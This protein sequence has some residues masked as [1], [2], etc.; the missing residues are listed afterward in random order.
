MN[1]RRVF[2]P[3][4]CEIVLF[5][6]TFGE[7]FAIEILGPEVAED[8]MRIRLRPDIRRHDRFDGMGDKFVVTAFGHAQPL[9]YAS[10]P[11][12]AGSALITFF[13]LCAEVRAARPIS[14]SRRARSNIAIGGAFPLAAERRFPSGARRARQGREVFYPAGAMSI[15]K[16]FCS[17]H[18]PSHS[19]RGISI[20]CRKRLL[21]QEGGGGRPCRM[22]IGMPERA[23]GT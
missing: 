16:C 13:S 1:C 20:N 8:H 11:E 10:H 14:A 23:T 17:A 12:G 19:W 5:L 22:T 21:H 7:Q 3:L 6:R 4:S 18:W 15:F 9:R 2:A